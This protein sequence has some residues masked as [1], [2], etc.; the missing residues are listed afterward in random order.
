M[1]PGLEPEVAAS[2]AALSSAEGRKAKAGRGPD[3]LGGGGKPL[4]EGG[5]RGVERGD[6]EGGAA[7][8]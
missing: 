7:T 5:G 8:R 6:S 4:C 1:S 3:A 2:L